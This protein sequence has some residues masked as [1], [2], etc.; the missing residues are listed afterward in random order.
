MEALDDQSFKQIDK[1]LSM[2]RQARKNLSMPYARH[3]G[4]GL[5]ELRDQRQSGPGYRLYY[6]WEGDVVVILLVGGNKDTQ[7]R[8]IQNARKRMNNED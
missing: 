5:L 2:L 8:D 7:E 6:Y 4:E 3:L 1:L